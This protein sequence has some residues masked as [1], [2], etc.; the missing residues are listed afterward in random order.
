M[1]E[2]LC[3]YEDGSLSCAFK[4]I[5]IMTQHQSYWNESSFFYL[6]YISTIQSV[7]QIMRLMAKNINYK[8]MRGVCFE[9]SCD[10]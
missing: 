10:V 7:S 2:I 1:R 9:F 5:C 4:L 3:D 6:N 8:Y